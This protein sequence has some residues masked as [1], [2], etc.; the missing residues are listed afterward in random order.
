MKN[1]ED[2]FSDIVSFQLNSQDRVEAELEPKKEGK[3]ATYN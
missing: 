1:Q 2:N 3:V